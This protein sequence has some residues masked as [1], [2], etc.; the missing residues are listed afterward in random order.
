MKNHQFTWN[1]ERIPPTEIAEV[2]HHL[3]AFKHVTV[4]DR[5]AVEDAPANFELGFDSADTL[6][7][8]SYQERTGIA[9]FDDKKF[10]RRSSRLGLMPRVS[11]PRA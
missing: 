3:L 9:S 4:E 5:A 10:A 8:A 6:H 7:H 11:V 2:F 1:L